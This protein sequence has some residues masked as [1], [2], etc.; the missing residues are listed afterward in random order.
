MTDV[1]RPAAIMAGRRPLTRERVNRY[2]GRAA[3]YAILVGGALLI[4]IPFLW[5]ISTAFKDISEIYRIPPVL[6]PGRLRVENLWL[7]MTVPGTPFTLYIA[8]TL[9]VAA[10]SMVGTLTANTAV[11]FAFSRLRWRGRDLWFAVMLSTMFLPA[12]VTMIPVYILYNNLGWIDTW[13]PLIVPHFFG[14]AW[15]VFLVRQFMMTIPLELDDAARID[16]CGTS[17]LFWH[18]IAP[19]SKPV[20]ATVAIFSFQFTWNDYFNPL[21][22]LSTRDKWT[23]ALALSQFNPGM[24]GLGAGWRTQEELLMAAALVL[25]LPLI[26]IFLSAQ[27]LFIQG[28]VISGVKG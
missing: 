7:S 6:I 3:A 27:R 26:I 19:L 28:I 22:Y 23:V 18:I 10:L 14:T 1:V 13:N 5:M 12:Q 8:N 4:S 20:I 17:R 11:A 9:Y 21:I 2:V 16:G 24:H 25:S 15:M